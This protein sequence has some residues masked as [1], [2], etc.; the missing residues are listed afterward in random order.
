M[1]GM[2]FSAPERTETNSGER[3]S[4]NRAP[5]AASNPS[6]PGSIMLKPAVCETARYGRRKLSLAAYKPSSGFI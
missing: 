1:P 5:V 3:S 4:P 6:I 2:D